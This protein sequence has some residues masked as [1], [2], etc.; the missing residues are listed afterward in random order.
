MRTA[1]VRV[2]RAPVQVWAMYMPVKN[3]P[4]EARAKAKAGNPTHSATHSEFGMYSAWGRLLSAMGAT[5]AT[6]RQAQLLGLTVTLCPHLSFAP[7]FVSSLSEMKVLPPTQRASRTHVLPWMHACGCVR[8]QRAPCMQERFPHP[9]QVSVS[10]RSSLVVTGDV[11]VEHLDLD[12][13]LV[14][15]ADPGTKLTIKSVVVRNDGWQMVRPV[16]PQRHACTGRCLQSCHSLCAARRTHAAH[17]WLCGCKPGLACRSG[18][19]RCRLSLSSCASA[20]SS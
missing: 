13:A 12:G 2:T 10:A 5:V 6:G 3:S 1:R 11:T 14:V 16:A 7:S 17:A 20:G 4:E 9:A 18:W 8:R 15:K 19:T